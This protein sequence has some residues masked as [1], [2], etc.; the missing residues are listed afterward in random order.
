MAA[1]KAAGESSGEVVKTLPADKAI[2]VKEDRPSMMYVGAR[3]ANKEGWK[4]LTDIPADRV[5]K[6]LPT[7][8]FVLAK[9]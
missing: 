5:L 9:K 4:K 1:K 7:G 2:F 6:R 8:M 3:S